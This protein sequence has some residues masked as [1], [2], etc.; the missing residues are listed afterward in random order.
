[1][2][3]HILLTKWEKDETGRLYCRYR[4]VD[5]SEAAPCCYKEALHQCTKQ[6]KEE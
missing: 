2:K 5:V 4:L 6:N 1:M 3:E